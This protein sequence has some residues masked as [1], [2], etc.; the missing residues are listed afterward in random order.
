MNNA[1][2]AVLLVIRIM[3]VI[4]KKAMKCTYFERKCAMLEQ[5][6]TIFLITPTLVRNNYWISY[7]K[8]NAGRCYQ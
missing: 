1:F 8:G 7:S 4:S 2:V 3:V 5:K 6:G